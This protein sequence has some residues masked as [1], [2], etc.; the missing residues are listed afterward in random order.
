MTNRLSNIA[1][2]LLAC[3]ASLPSFANAPGKTTPVIVVF[4]EAT[5]FHQ[6][7]GN[8]HPD[9]R[10]I[11]HAAAWD[12]LDRGVMGAAQRLENLHRFKS[13]HVFSHAV[14]GFAADLST[15]Q[16]EALKAE[17]TVAYIEADLPVTADVQSLPWGV[18]RVEA[19]VSSTLAGNG[20]GSV[21]GVNVYVVDSGIATHQDLNLVKHVNFAGGSNTDCNGH[22]T[23]VAG[24][25]GAA[26]N[27]VD[28]VGVA[29]GV[30]L[31]GVK[32]LDCNGSGTT[33][34]VIKGIDWVTANAVKPA[35]ANMSLGGGVS[36]TLD[37]ALRRSV[38][39]QVTIAL[40]AG[41]SGVDA[42][43]SSPARAG[44]NANGL[45]NGIITT[46]A[47]DTYGKEAS[48]SNYGQCV[49]IWAPGVN[50][51]STR[52]G[53]GTATMSG[54][55]MASPHVAGAAALYLSRNP[56]ATPAQVES[57]LRSFSMTPGT[58]SKDG[59]AIQ[60]LQVNAF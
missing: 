10:A 21:A 47:T 3:A 48:F 36:Q 55:S 57:A 27:A 7:K 2:G 59:R 33:S 11:A 28:V 41:N 43:N 58:A 13:K 26:D 6:F 22:G 17:P 34:T 19:D 12:Y 16:I 40:A 53:G 45:D 44:Y 56:S 15:E 1:L 8:A 37:D 35:V 39:A 9:E 54:T 18:D 42:C 29:P 23:H 51:V 5:P 20:S 49:N 25:I 46:A 32:V 4:Q 30:R 38:G 52:A 31:I 14:K 24:T 60:V 50:I